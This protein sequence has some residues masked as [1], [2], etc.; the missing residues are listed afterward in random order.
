MDHSRCGTLAP[1]CPAW[2]GQLFSF[3][4]M[5]LWVRDH[6]G[7]AT[8]VAAAA[9]APAGD[10]NSV[11]APTR[12]GKLQARHPA[13]Q[14]SPTKGATC[15]WAGPNHHR[16][17]VGTQRPSAVHSPRCGSVPPLHRGGNCPGTAPKALGQDPKRTQDNQPFMEVPCS[18]IWARTLP[19]TESLCPDSRGSGGKFPWLSG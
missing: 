16:P 5:T 12:G 6:P 4:A 7:Q 1:P 9:E 19:N 3:R 8:T 11:Q 10:W 17:P 2:P 15:S 18:V 14:C 13:R